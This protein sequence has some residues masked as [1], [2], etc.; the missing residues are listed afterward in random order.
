[1]SEPRLISADS[2]VNEPG[3]LWA[4]RIE[5]PFRDRAPHVVDNPP[6]LR[7]GAYFMLQGIPPV[8]LPPLHVPPVHLPP[9]L[10]SSGG[11]QH[12]PNNSVNG[13]LRY[14]LG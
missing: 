9:V 1:M 4:E 11:H 2:H 6:G 5:K 7:P 14:L 8:H 10:G 3:D 12:T 13:L